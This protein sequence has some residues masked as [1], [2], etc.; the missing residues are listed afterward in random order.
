M[1]N[2][3]QHQHRL[4]NSSGRAC[5]P[6]PSKGLP[7]ISQVTSDALPRYNRIVCTL[8]TTSRLTKPIKS[9]GVAQ[10]L[11]LAA[12]F[13]ACA[14][15]L[16]EIGSS[17]CQRDI[18]FSKETFC[19]SVVSKAGTL[20]ILIVPCNLRRDSMIAALNDSKL[21][22][23]IGDRIGIHIRAVPIGPPCLFRAPI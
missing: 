11:P 18:F 10:F 7:F 22:P 14:T 3:H 1:T 21:T 5:R 8:H 20:Q 4:C 15:W 19:V 13:G 2:S 6:W 16:R 9:N 23:P 12:V 17:R